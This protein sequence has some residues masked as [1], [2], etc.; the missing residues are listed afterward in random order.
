MLLMKIVLY[1]IDSYLMS[2]SQS[3]LDFLYKY[4]YMISFPFHNG[5]Q[6]SLSDHLHHPLHLGQSIKQSKKNIY[7]AAT[8]IINISIKIFCKKIR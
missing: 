6:S 5:I 8:E 3:H 4:I 2:Y 1:E 7:K